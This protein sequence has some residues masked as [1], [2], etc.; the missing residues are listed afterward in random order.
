MARTSSQPPPAS[1]TARLRR[2]TRWLW[3]GALALLVELKFR[4]GEARLLLSWLV[5]L[6]Y[7]PPRV[8][9][10]NY[11]VVQILEIV[12]DFPPE[13]ALARRARYHQA[14]ADPRMEG[15][16]VRALETVPSVAGL[17]MMALAPPPLPVPCPYWYWM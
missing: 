9:G 2:G 11:P 6:P 16:L 1:A 13:V 7:V 15:T 17:A 4:V 5:P 3:A 8:A 10:Y 12:D 14:L